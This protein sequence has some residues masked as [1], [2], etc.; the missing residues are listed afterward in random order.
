[1]SPTA[2]APLQVLGIAILTVALSSDFLPADEPGHQAL[3]LSSIS[4]VDPS[5]HG[6]SSLSSEG[7][8]VFRDWIGSGYWIAN[9]SA[10]TEVA[11][12]GNAAPGG[13]IFSD[14][15]FSGGYFAA[16][17]TGDFAFVADSKIGT[18]TKEGMF[19]RRG[20][21]L[22]RLAYEGT[23]APGGGVFGQFH[24]GFT[25]YG[26]QVSETGWV[27][28]LAETTGGPGSGIYIG[29]IEGGASVVRKV[30]ALSDAAPDGGYF[31]NLRPDYQPS[32]AVLDDGRVCFQGVTST[33][34]KTRLYFWDG[35]GLAVVP[36]SDDVEEFR[37]NP[38][39]EICFTRYQY[40]GP[41]LMRGTPAGTSPIL[42]YGDILPGGGTV[43]SV[44]HPAINASG[45]VAFLGKRTGGP[46][47]SGIFR[48]DAGGTKVISHLTG[49]AAG[50]GNFKGGTLGRLTLTNPGRIYWLSET[51][52]GD[53]VFMGDGNVVRRVIGPGTQL[54]GNVVSTVEFDSVGFAL[55]SG[56]GPADDAGRVVY[57]AA[58]QNNSDSGI[59]RFT[60]PIGWD[61]SP[62][63]EITVQQPDLVEAADG[64]TRSFGTVITGSSS[65]LTFQIKNTGLTNLTGIS[66]SIDG[67]HAADY[68]ITS[69]PANTV[70]GPTGVTPLTIRFQPL[71][72]GART[73][74]LRIASNDADENPYDIILVG[75][76]SAPEISVEHPD[77]SP[78]VSEVGSIDFGTV[79][80][81]SASSS[82]TFRVRNLGQATLSLSTITKVGGNPAAFQVNTASM[83]ASVA[84]GASTTF[85]VSFQPGT[86]G[87]AS[88]SLRIVN[89]DLDENPF[90][91]SLGGN[92]IVPDIEVEP[93][94]GTP[95]T[96]GV[97]TISFGSH[98]IGAQSSQSFTIRNLGEAPLTLGSVS[99][100]GGHPDFSPNLAG[101]SS[102]VPSGG[103]TTFS[104]RFAPTVAGVRSATLRILSNDADET[105]F[106]IALT[107]NGLAP[108]IVVESPLGT[109]LAD[110]GSLPYGTADV[111]QTGTVRV[112]TIRNS[113]NSPLTLTGVET[114]TGHPGDFL[115]D[116][117]GLATDLAPGQTTSFSVAMVP[118]AIGLRTTWLRI[119][120]NDSDE[121]PFD[122]ALSGTGTR[123]EIAVEQPVGTELQDAISSVEFAPVGTGSTGAAKTFVIRNLGET[124]LTISGVTISGAA[125]A[126]FQV[127]TVGML[128]SLVPGAS[129]SFTV[130]FSPT[131]VGQINAMASIQSNDLNENPFRIALTGQGVVN[132]LPVIHLAGASAHTVEADATYA[133]PGA[134]A[135][136]AEDGPL[137]P[138]ISGNTVQPRLPGTYQVRWSVTDSLSGIAT[139][140]RTVQV[141]DTTAPVLTLPTDIEVNAT[142]SAGAVVTYPAAVATD[143]VGVSSLTYSKASGSLFPGGSTVVTVRAAD[144][145]GNSRE[146]TFSVTVRPGRMDRLAPVIRLLTPSTRTTT[147]AATFR[148]S[149]TVSENF[150]LASFVVRCNGVALDLDQPLLLAPGVSAPWSVSEVSAENGPNLIEVEA[151]D[152]SGRRTRLTKTVT[153]TNERP[154]LGG[155]YSAWIESVQSPGLDTCGLVTVTL[156]DKGSFTG[157]L[158]L[159]G[160][161]QAFS[162]VLRNDAT[163]RFNGASGNSVEFRAGRAG[164]LRSL[165]FLSFQVSETVG[166]SGSLLVGG[167]ETSRFEAPKA[168]YGRDLRVD[169]QRTGLY[170]LTHTPK[171]QL[172]G[173]PPI[174]YPQ[175]TGCSSLLLNDLGMVSWAGYLADGSKFTTSGRLRADQTLAFFVP[176]YRSLG[177]WG[178]EL[179]LTETPDSDI[180]GSDHLWLRPALSKSPHYS[181]GWP[182]GVRLDAVGTAF[183][184]PS[185]WNLGQGPTEPLLG[186]LRLLFDVIPS[187]SPV[188]IGAN[189]NPATGSAV[190]V[191]A[192]RST[193][194]LA[195]SS[196]SGLFSGTF[197]DGQGRR[198][199]YRGILL[200]KGANTGGFGFFLTPGPDGVSRP[201]SLEPRTVPTN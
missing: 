137:T 128:T 107:G 49:P 19:F 77:T 153:F 59:F 130:A 75:T 79:T 154:A 98:L 18:V 181:I 172:S 15:G 91:I 138:F 43:Y 135:T 4:E 132:A 126:Q 166:L 97:G 5:P 54:A 101:M 65:S 53:A 125:A 164:S 184:T 2:F 195:L 81:G 51:S 103:Q 48:W 190:V 69:A 145:A 201:L 95:L 176:L 144:A 47:S 60:P 30:A 155:H 174:A 165:G 122:L 182:G 124:N 34:Y 96:A 83:S 159:G 87:Q 147:V 61:A 6:P 44:D 27:V 133:D 42:T 196:R 160:T 173:L 38:S 113:G 162:G 140:T 163:A 80:A 187:T 149:G 57:Q 123:P 120:S 199:S 168:P 56:N 64:T 55:T 68:V 78:L 127:R 150:A 13:G 12:G 119:R 192:Q 7:S 67:T 118:T 178:G 94:G 93:F 197:R 66:A 110:G 22:H 31:T 16:S 188:E 21:V 129:T 70:T 179:A 102:T 52:G 106:D 148:L 175:G 200:G 142:S 26:P 29:R 171:E 14:Y 74:T 183:R 152:F 33:N 194:S 167:Q 169:A 8:V 73:A 82:K 40:N 161:S 116:S 72:T 99:W 143:L 25:A 104:V 1:M 9:G 111:G 117:T 105:P 186:N 63:R 88:T 170:N 180:A 71:G 177:G 158:S 139:A 36:G 24:Y 146:G 62:E 28:F 3:V 115:I 50:G 76:G 20:G 191:S 134:T 136:D 141:L 85:S 112:Y 100:A 84:P 45:Q 11:K 39:G 121:N 92:A 108:E 114:A 23:A 41:L 189:L 46:S 185:A 89:N 193:S 32:W 58:L 109:N 156:T 10:V 37:M 17:R 90:V 198:L 157:R 35:S 86:A 131:S 151:L